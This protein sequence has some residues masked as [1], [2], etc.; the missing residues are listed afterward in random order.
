MYKYIF[1]SFKRRNYI[2]LCIKRLFIEKEVHVRSTLSISFPQFI[3]FHIH[4][5][6]RNIICITTHFPIYF[7]CFMW[8][9]YC[10]KCKTKIPFKMIF[11]YIQTKF[12]FIK[13]LFIHIKKFNTESKYQKIFKDILMFYKFFI[14]LIS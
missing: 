9:C 13:T 11:P 7:L 8:K 3:I 12:S 4:I 5:F 14:M 6:K 2:M 1:K 10:F